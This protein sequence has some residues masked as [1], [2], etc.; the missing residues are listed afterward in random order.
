MG[1]DDLL[2]QNARYAQAL[3]STDFDGIAHAGVLIITCMDSRI[4]PLRMV[5]L[6]LGDAKIIR[7]PGGF[8]TDEVVRGSVLATHLLQVNR[9]MVVQ[10]TKC[11]M[12]QGWDQD[13]SDRV[14]D[15]TGADVSTLPFHATPDQ[16][17]RLRHD[18]ALLRQEPLLQGRCEVGGFMYDVDNGLLEQIF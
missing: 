18:I 9:I 4:D 8:V 5:G 1:F 14:R 2:A 3:P 12:A 6:D 10:H 11:A 15:A 7:T 16:M 17:G 13:L